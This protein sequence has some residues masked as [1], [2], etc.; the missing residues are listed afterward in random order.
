MIPT[1]WEEGEPLTM[2]TLSQNQ[3]KLE[4]RFDEVQILLEEM[5]A[6]DDE[7]KKK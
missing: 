1:R 2:I 3:K 7:T 6:V 4:Y 5:R